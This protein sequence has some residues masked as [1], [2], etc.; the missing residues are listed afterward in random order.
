MNQHVM[1]RLEGI[2]KSLLGIYEAN[3]T[4]SSASKGKEREDFVNLFCLKF[5]LFHIVSA[6]EI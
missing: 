4:M 3:S 6:L 5:F 1:Y 2:R